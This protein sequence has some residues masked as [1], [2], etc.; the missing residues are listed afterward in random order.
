MRPISRV[1]TVSTLGVTQI[2]AWGS[3]YYL[4]AVLAHPIAEGLGISAPTV[5][6]GFS[7][8]LVVAALLG[9]LAGRSIDRFGGRPVLMATNLIFSL[10]LCLLA[11]AQDTAGMLIAWLVIGIGMGGG[12]YEAAFSTLVRLYGS[13]SRAAIT[14]VTLVAGLAS[15]LAWPLSAWLEV[16]VG[17]RGAC[18][19]WAALHLL[20]ALPLNWSLPKARKVDESPVEAV[21]EPEAGAT[22]ASRPR[23]TS[24]LLAMSFALIWFISTAMAAH[25]PG[26]LMLSGATLATAV[27]VGAMVGPAQVAGRLVEF[28]ALRHL[29][30]LRS[31][32]VA[33]L[34]HPIAAS[35]LAIFGAP[36]AALFALLHGAGNGM[37]TIATGTLPLALFGSKGYGM[38]QGLLMSPARLFQALAPWLFGLWI[39]AWGLAAMWVSAGLGLAAFCTLLALGRAEPKDP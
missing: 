6:G 14:G 36:A 1:R 10:G 27:A 3:S 11:I 26:L 5:F 24:A 38:R 21:D 30:P 28:T 7:M 25:L 23:M 31:A 12:L 22:I 4:P 19:T 13:D 33:V 39:E 17:W 32:R 35:A 37:L 18:Y 8:A 34:L 15:T 2:F 9:P 16:Q 20:L 29:H